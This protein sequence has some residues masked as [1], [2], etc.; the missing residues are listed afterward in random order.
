[1]GVGTE[2]QAMFPWLQSQGSKAAQRKESD[3]ASIWRQ[4][5][6][7]CKQQQRAFVRTK[8]GARKPKPRPA[9]GTH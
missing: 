5:Q 4:V 6:I 2:G 9:V 1:M 3:T 8:S 7:A